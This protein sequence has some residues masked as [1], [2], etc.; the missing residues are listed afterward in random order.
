MA[1]FG[2]AAIALTL[3][4]CGKAADKAADP[5]SIKQAI[6]ADEAKWNQDFKSKDTER[7]AEHY[8]D[9][10]YFVAPGLAPANGDT[11]IRKI[12]ATGSTDPAFEVEFASDKID[13]GAGGDMAYSRGHFTEK[14]TDQ[15]TSK[16]MSTS[17]SYLA[18]YKKQA[19]GKWKVVEDFVASDPDATKPVAPAKA[20]RHAQMTSSGF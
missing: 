8:A 2:A 12:Y 5:D 9:D 14:Y 19:D 13:V 1:L 10:A 7:L 20:A 15:K 3:G 18:V 6:K 16:V 11:E 4:A 17:G